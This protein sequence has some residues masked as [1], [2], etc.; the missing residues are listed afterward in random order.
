MSLPERSQERRAGSV[1]SEASSVGMLLRGHLRDVSCS[2]AGALSASAEEAYRVSICGSSRHCRAQQA[3][4]LVR[5]SCQGCCG[6]GTTESP[7]TGHKGG[8][9]SVYR[10]DIFS[11]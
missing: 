10:V 11:F 7:Y 9:V 5:R 3:A 1:A 2:H 4:L 8:T 6:K